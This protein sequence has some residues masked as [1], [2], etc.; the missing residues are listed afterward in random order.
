MY[1]IIISTADWDNP[2]WTNKQHVAKTLADMGHHVLYIDSLGM[3]TPT[4]SASDLSRIYKRLI[5][6]FSGTQKINDNI[7]IMSPFSIPLQKYSIVRWLNKFILVKMINHTAQKLNFT[8]IILWT[9]NPLTSYLIDNIKN[10]KSIYHCVDE[11]SAQPSMPKQTIQEAEINLLKK[12]D[13]TFVT[14]LSLLKEKQQY[15]KNCFYY[16]NV[17]DFNHFNTAYTSKFEIP[18][19]LPTDKKNIGFIGA[20]SGYKQNFVLIASLAEQRPQYNIILIGK[21]GEGDP[22]TNA[23][24]LE[25]YP[26][27]FLLGAKNY[28]E[29]PQYLSFFDVCMLPCC[30][31]TYTKYMFPMKF[32]EYLAAAKPVVSTAIPAINDFK[33]YCYIAKTNAQFISFVD[34]AIGEDSI[35]LQKKRLLL[36][37]QYTYSIRTQKMLRTIA[38]LER[39]K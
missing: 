34:K 15:S 10:G 29:L 6:L 3:R 25:Q 39:T 13:I 21:I 17:A 24:I 11:I 19:D 36:A 30:I 8:N 14:T 16:P 7:W 5:K 38:T 1:F 2:F 35:L 22:H 27:I 33:D 20:I 26:N 23:S 9:Y 18:P 12:V 32:F 37:K 31:N 28:L 4:A